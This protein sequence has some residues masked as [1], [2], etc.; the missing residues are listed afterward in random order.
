[1]QECDTMNMIDFHLELRNSCGTKRR[2]FEKF[3]ANG[4]EK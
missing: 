1:M 4:K 3:K 2:F